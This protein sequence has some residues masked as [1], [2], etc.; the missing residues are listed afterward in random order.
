MTYYDRE[1]PINIAYLDRDMDRLRYLFEVENYDID[2]LLSEKGTGRDF[3]YT[4][5]QQACID[6]FY[7]L[8]EY[9]IERGIDM[10]ECLGFD[11]GYNIYKNIL[12]LHQALYKKNYRVFCLMVR[13]GADVNIICPFTGRSAL[14]NLCTPERKDSIKYMKELL[15]SSAEVNIL[16]SDGC[17]PLMLA[18]RYGKM[19]EAEMLVRFGADPFILDDGGRSCE[20]ILESYGIEVVRLDFSLTVR[21][22]MATVSMDLPVTYL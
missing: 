10:N 11:S 8:A 6:D 9:L 3:P 2:G 19:K 17:T 15:D 16:D 20:S 1:D 18:C 4:I 21:K 12:L 22:L 5:F 7:E 14:H 13:K